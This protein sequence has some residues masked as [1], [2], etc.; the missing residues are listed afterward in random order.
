MHYVVVSFNFGKT[1]DV[2][3][4]YLGSE[5]YKAQEISKRLEEE[6]DETSDE[7]NGR[8]LLVDLLEVD[9]G[10]AN[11]GGHTCFWPCNDA[12][13]VKTLSTNN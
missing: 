11:D 13:G 10:F 6:S 2:K 4:H 8:K 3:L 12:K 1:N 5:P 7:M 9:E